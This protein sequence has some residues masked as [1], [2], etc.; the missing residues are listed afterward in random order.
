MIYDSFAFMACFPKVREGCVALMTSSRLLPRRRQMSS[1]R[2]TEFCETFFRHVSSLNGCVSH[3]RLR[4]SLSAKKN[5][6]TS[7]LN[8]TALLFTL[9]SLPE[10]RSFVSSIRF[11]TITMSIKIEIL[12]STRN[13][14]G[15][16]N[17]SKMTQSTVRVF[18]EK[19]ISQKFFPFDSVD[20]S[21]D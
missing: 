14:D 10:C 3:R 6:K 17:Y 16:M 18:S 9:F 8:Y 11:M 15:L 19:R 12:A 21:F 20:G 4:E 2:F 13:F 7:L 1:V 5:I